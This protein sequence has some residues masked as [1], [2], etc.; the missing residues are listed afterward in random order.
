MFDSSTIRHACSLA[1]EKGTARMTY[2]QMKE[3]VEKLSQTLQQYVKPG[4]V[5]CVLADRSI[6]WIVALFAV[7]NVSA[8]YCPVDVDHSE[9]QQQKIIK[10]SRAVMVLCDRIE[11]HRSFDA[12]PNERV[13]SLAVSEILQSTAPCYTT[14]IRRKSHPTSGSFLV[15][16]SG[17]TGE[18]K[19]ES[20]TSPNGGLLTVQCPYRYTDQQRFLNCFAKELWSVQ[21]GYGDAYT[22]CRDK[23][24]SNWI[25]EP[26]LRKLN[27]KSWRAALC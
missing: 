9:I 3:K 15:F 27:G 6:N 20:P 11:Q 10:L 22:I 16:T 2:G 18:P 1:I 21:G 5:V 24:G 25:S 26:T 13:M 4:D 19:G 7:I 14:E 12:L 23:F 17:S 8:I